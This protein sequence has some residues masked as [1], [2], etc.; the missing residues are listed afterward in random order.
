MPNPATAWT[1]VRLKQP[2]AWP[3]RALV[4]GELES[5]DFSDC[6]RQ[7]RQRTDAIEVADTEQAL[8]SAA[9]DP[10]D[11]I[12]IAAERPGG[13]SHR[14]VEAM[15]QAAPLAHRGA[16]REL[17]RGG[18]AERPALARGDACL[19][20]FLGGLV[21]SR[22]VRAGRRGVRRTSRCH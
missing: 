11:L 1:S 3:R 13:F 15:R 12:I 16:A 4:T 18:I 20:A 21:R 19:L 10:P 14:Q 5:P 8:A 6:R 2:A 7:I 9:Q 17:V 22:D